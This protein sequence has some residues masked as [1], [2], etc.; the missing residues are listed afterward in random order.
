MGN[1]I[2][3]PDELRNKHIYLPGNP[4]HGKTT[5]MMALAIQDIRKDRGVC[6]IDP[7]GDAVKT[8]IH[9][10]PSYRVK[11]TIELSPKRP[12]PIDFM[13]YDQTDPIAKDRLVGDLIYI[14]EKNPENTK[15]MVP[16][17]RRLI[18]TILDSPDRTFLDIYYFFEWPK[19]QQT[20]LANTTDENRAYWKKHPP[21]SESV[22]ALLARIEIYELVPTLRTIFGTPTPQ[23]NV[24]DIVESNKILLA[25]LDDSD[26][27]KLLG[28]LLVT[29]IKQIAFRRRDIHQSERQP[30]CLYCDEFQEFQTPDFE[31][32]ITQGRKY[33]IWLTVANQGMYQLD[34][35]IRQAVQRV[36]TF[37][38]FCLG[39]DDVRYFKLL[40]S[41]PKEELDALQSR[42]KSGVISE[43]IKYEKTIG[44]APDRFYEQ[45]KSFDPENPDLGSILHDLPQYW[46]VFK[47]GHEPAVLSRILPRPP[48]NPDTCAAEI[49]ANMNKYAK[50]AQSSP[51]RSGDKPSS[52]TGKN[53]S[54]LEGN[55]DRD[56]PEPKGQGIY[57]THHAVLPDEPKD[58]GPQGSR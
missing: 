22:E 12:I 26:A 50:D 7:A 43:I 47:I 25:D 57:G 19:R 2:K 45:L 14:L 52:H 58:K 20:L 13:E 38:I 35:A 9:W 29:K 36:S 23:L 16:L 49:R 42:R 55:A 34:E 5:Q 39:Q 44:F 46:A 8:L 15:R 18:Y 10:I 28:Q 53:V 41:R 4:G 24:R 54:E 32:I 27:G 3:I 1:P 56:K 37:I 33:Q 11:D 40:V 48:A 17:L 51:I 31:K 21:K 30:Y 6:F